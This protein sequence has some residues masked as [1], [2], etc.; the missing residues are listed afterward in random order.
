M[1]AGACLL[2]CALLLV[3]V[4]HGADDA[5][6]ESPLD[7]VLRP[8][9]ELRERLNGRGLDYSLAYSPQLQQGNQ[10]SRKTTAN[11]ELDF[12]GEWELLESERAGSG[13]F[14]WWFVHRRTLG[15]LTTEEF[16]DAGGA[17]SAYALNGG[18]TRD[19]RNLNRLEYFYWQQLLLDDALRI[20]VGKVDAEF[21]LFQSDYVGTPRQDFFA[22]VVTGNE[23]A[24]MHRL[25]GLGG[26]ASY[27]RESWSLSAMVRDA[28]ADQDWFDLSHLQRGNRHAAVELALTPTIGELG[29]GTWRAT[30][31]HHDE[32]TKTGSSG[33][34]YAVSIDQALGERYAAFF[35]YARAE[36][37][38]Q[39]LRTQ[40]ATGVMFL[41]PVG[42]AHD[43]AGIAFSW[44]QPS[45]TA[46]DDV[47]DQYAIEAMW[48]LQLTR[49]IQLTPD[50]QF[51]WDP[52]TGGERFRFVS[53][54][55]LR[56]EL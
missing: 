19:D 41:A 47:R 2:A 23:V 11:H 36:R 9:D 55:R 5:Y 31:Y 20:L 6:F 24:A 43:L 13:G 33:Y 44:A 14:E 10:K 1:R 26:L 50:F 54:L 27:T 51:I 4:A 17:G 3:R 28:E 34:A 45:S 53:G 25:A 7:G 38:L 49:R 12:V 40:L 30:Y 22:D 16:S 39:R 42:S 18:D 56:I 35:R 29:P 32:T 46:P 21:L 15:G 48:R 8:W 37:Q 52:A